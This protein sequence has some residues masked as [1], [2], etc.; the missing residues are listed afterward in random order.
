[1]FVN[2]QFINFGTFQFVIPL[3]IKNKSISKLAMIVLRESIFS[4]E[5]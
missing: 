4:D 2:I 5:L 1:M 3:K